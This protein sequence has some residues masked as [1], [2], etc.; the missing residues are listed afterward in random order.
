MSFAKASCHLSCS[1]LKNKSITLKISEMHLQG[2]GDNKECPWQYLP[3]NC[4]ILVPN[5]NDTTLLPKHPSRH[6]NYCLMSFRMCRAQNSWMEFLPRYLSIG[7]PRMP[8]AQ[9][10]F[11]PRDCRTWK[12]QAG[13]LREYTGKTD[14]GQNSVRRGL[15]TYYQ[16]PDPRLPW[17]K[18]SRASP[19]HNL[20]IYCLR[21]KKKKQGDLGPVM[22]SPRPGRVFLTHQLSCFP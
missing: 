1:L 4:D 5:F 16:S 20:R 14:G 12:D 10:E 17:R 21:K 11:C 18:L 8:K 2:L 19:H 15:Q 6:H 9:V 22:D 7:I 3:G 13:Q